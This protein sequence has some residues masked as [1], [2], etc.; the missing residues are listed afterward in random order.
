LTTAIDQPWLHDL[1]R[2]VQHYGWRYDYKV[3][4]I[5]QDLRIG[6]IPDWLAGLCER[7][8]AEGIF[9]R[10]PD[11]VIINEYQIGPK[12]SPRMSIA[13]HASATLSHPSALAL[14]ASWTSPTPPPAKNNPTC[15]S[16]AACSYY[17]TM[18][19]TTGN[20]PYLLANPING[21]ARPFHARA[22][23]R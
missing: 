10:A 12:A 14:A 5:T 13:C 21:A 8:S 3:R 9:S 4:G 23:F 17:S 2:R 7:L 1:K 19:A 18:R 22:V 15:W 11:Q 6:V 16:R 20:T